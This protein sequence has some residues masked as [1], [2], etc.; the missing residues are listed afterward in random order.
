VSHATTIA[1]A[2]AE[3]TQRLAN[4]QE[5]RR[6]AEILLGHLLDRARGWLLAFSEQPLTADQAARFTALVERRAAGEPVAYLLGERGFWRFDLSVSPATLIPRP[7][8]E[9]LVELALERLPP[10][11]EWAVAD[12]GTG[13][14]AIAL[15]IA[16]ERPHCRVVAVDSSS[17]ALSVA[18]EN[19]RR[20]GLNQVEWRHGEWYGPLQGERF[21]LLLAN[22][23]Y[24]AEGDPHLKQ[25]DLR[26]EPRSALAAGADGLDDLRQLIAGAAA[27]LLPGGWLLL[28]HGFDQGP[29]V[30]QLLHEAGLAEIFTQQDLAGC[31]RVSGGRLSTSSE[32]TNG[33][34]AEG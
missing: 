24:I 34:S 21:A 8:T 30:T 5:G 19:G 27:H 20:L 23:P 7:E 11:A 3:A 18:T 26:F 33:P 4:Q 31:D 25:G 14:G 22:P 1:A 6:E 29:A 12:L 32:A 13:S 17:A 28:E 10:L 15:A 16:L 9:L 2:L